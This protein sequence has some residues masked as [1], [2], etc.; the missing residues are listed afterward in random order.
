MI[1]SSFNTPYDCDYN[2]HKS[3]STY[4]ADLDVARAH[5]VGSVIRTGLQR[6]NAG[7]EEGLPAEVRAVKGKYYVALGAIGCF[8]VE[9]LMTTVGVRDQLAQK[10]QTH[11]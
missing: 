7:D 9:M 8:T 6:L 11:T 5:Y 4:F 10:R 1:T 3:N 2:L